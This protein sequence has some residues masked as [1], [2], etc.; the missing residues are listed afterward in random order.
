MRL[1]H[2]LAELPENPGKWV[3]TNVESVSIEGENIFFNTDQSELERV[4]SDLKDAEKFLKDSEK[5]KEE[6]EKERDSAERELEKAQETLNSYEISPTDTI[7]DLV[8]RN[9]WQAEQLTTYKTTCANHLNRFREMERE[10]KEL[11]A[12]KNKASVK[13]CLTTGK[14]IA[15]FNDKGYFLTEKSE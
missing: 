6:A 11:R 14:L 10:I 12:R 5:E 2:L 13:R 1:I 4:K 3:F 15:T 7:G 9:E 8:E